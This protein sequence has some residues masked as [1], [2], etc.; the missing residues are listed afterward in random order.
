MIFLERK[1]SCESA[2]H[3]PNGASNNKN[4]NTYMRCKI[5]I[6]KHFRLTLPHES[7][8]KDATYAIYHYFLEGKDNGT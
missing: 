7:E 1:K 5:A 3:D 4:L 8:G 2:T 6:R